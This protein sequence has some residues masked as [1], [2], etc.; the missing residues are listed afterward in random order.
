MRRTAIRAHLSLVIALSFVP[1]FLFPPAIAAGLGKQ[2]FHGFGTA[3]QDV[4]I[5]L[6]ARL[7]T[8]TEAEA[9]AKK[10]TTELHWYRSLPEAEA[11]A[12]RE[13]K[14]IFWMHMLGDIDGKT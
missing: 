8:G 3:V 4:G 5:P 10:L 11:Q 14:P 12:R 6:P 2:L 7:E 9:N 13:N 1:S